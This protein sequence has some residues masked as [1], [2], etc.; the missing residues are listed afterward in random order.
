M[1]DGSNVQYEFDTAYGHYMVVDMIYD[2]RRARVLFSGDRQAAQSGIAYDDNPDL[3]FDYNQR[4]CELVE[5]IQPQSLLL[6]GGGMYTLPT[7]LLASLSDIRIDVVELD[8]GLEAVARQYFGLTDDP[9]L[10]IINTDGLD[11]LRNNH[12]HYDMILIDAYTHASAEPTLG[13]LEAIQLLR[14]SLTSEGVVAANVIAAYF[15]RR[16]EGLKKLVDTYRQ[17]FGAVA[18]YPASQSLSLWLPQN[19]LLTAQVMDDAQLDQYLRYR[20]LEP[21]AQPFNLG[22]DLFA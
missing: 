14:T 16:S 22:H 18:L 6:I 20:R 1:S 19:L 11:Y 8:E 17:Q 9:R 21:S 3:L 10:T 5:G 15:G 2:S 7:A 13:S 12:T 4:M